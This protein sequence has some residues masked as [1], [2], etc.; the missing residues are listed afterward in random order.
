[1]SNKGN[2]ASPVTYLNSMFS[3]RQTGR[4]LK[5]SNLFLLCRWWNTCK[6]KGSS[7]HTKRQVGRSAV[8]R[9]L[10]GQLKWFRNNLRNRRDTINQIAK[11]KVQHSRVLSSNSSGYFYVCLSWQRTF[12]IL[13]T[14]CFLFWYNDGLSHSVNQCTQCSFDKHFLANF[15]LIFFLQVLRSST[16]QFI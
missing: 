10:T 3:I 16:P 15:R 2:A 11:I 1:M 12:Y 7:L 8:I 4:L 5:E 14:M 13:G 9:Y 6:K